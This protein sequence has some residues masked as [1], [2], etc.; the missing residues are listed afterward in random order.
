MLVIP[1]EQLGERLADARKRAKLTQAQVAE[2]VGI[3]RTTMV[4]IE[5]GERR[6]TDLELISLAEITGVRLND[7]LRPHAVRAV[8]SAV[9]LRAGMSEHDAAA[10]NQAI[11]AVRLRA[12]RYVELE[13]MLEVPR[14][15]APIEAL[16]LYQR[17]TPG[18][19]DP[20]REAADAARAVRALLGL[21]DEAAHQIEARFETGAGL[22]I[23]RVALPIKVR[24][25]LLWGEE[26]GACVALNRDHSETT[27]RW[28]LAYQLGM[29]LRNRDEGHVME[30]ESSQR[31]GGFAE[32]FAKEL[33]LPATGIERR[34]VELCRLGKFTP[35]Q[36]HDLAS[37]FGVPF[38]AMA[39]RLEE[40]RL[41]PDDTYDGI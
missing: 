3:A 28:S 26:I 36:L 41:L 29:F 27:Q 6:P 21:G 14:L 11:D 16:Q 18:G 40:L 37:S 30:L 32:A 38:Q 23:F 20:R 22:R 34:F 13:R 15:V 10:V 35:L 19:M 1:S 2:R 9:R 17:S 31:D 5:K 12:A 25:I 33:L 7:L 4:A 39:L 8:S 24:A